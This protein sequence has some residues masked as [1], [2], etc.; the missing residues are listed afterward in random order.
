MAPPLL[1]S[2]LMTSTQK[3]KILAIVPKFDGKGEFFTKVGMGFRNKDQSI[4][5][6]LESLPLPALNGKP[7]KLQVREWDERDDRPREAYRS[8]SRDVVAGELGAGASEYAA[9]A[10]SGAGSGATNELPF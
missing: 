7:M 4:N 8:P 10:G 6:F 9:S 5:L 3:F 2:R 1:L